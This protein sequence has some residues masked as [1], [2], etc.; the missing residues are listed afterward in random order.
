MRRNDRVDQA[1]EAHPRTGFLPAALRAEAGAD[2][3]LPIGGGQTSSQPR[4]VAAMLRLL[5]VPPGARVLDVGA[6]SGWTTALLGHLVGPQGVVV[7][8]ELDPDLAAWGALNVSAAGQPWTSLLPA[9][10][11][12]LGRPDEAPF[13]RVLVSAEA[14]ELPQALVRQ[15]TPVGRM[16]IPVRREML[17]VERTGP[18]DDDLRVTGHGS[19]RFV[20]LR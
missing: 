5:E 20:P 9:E 12:V 13:D 11:G 4:T 14:R 7:G 19:Y 17:L 2:R 16:V 18:A 6:G 1:F 10:P 8:V 15:L 3:P